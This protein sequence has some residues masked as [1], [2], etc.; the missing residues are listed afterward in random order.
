M[1]KQFMGA[2]GLPDAVDPPVASSAK[3]P[4]KAESK[5]AVTPV[6]AEPVVAPAPSEF[7]PVVVKEEPTP[8]S[9]DVSVVPVTA[10]SPIKSPAIK[11]DKKKSR[12]AD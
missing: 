4:V 11:K 6:V 9:V 1:M 10:P 2:Q 3:A 8:E 7:E 12:R 5:A